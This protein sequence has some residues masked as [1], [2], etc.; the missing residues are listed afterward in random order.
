MPLSTDDR[1]T[2][3]DAALPIA[4]EAGALLMEGWRSASSRARAKS[5]SD[6]VTDYD[7][8]SEA[9]IRE[10]L[11]ARFPDCAFIGEEGGGQSA[12]RVWYVD[13][14]DGT[15][16]FAHGHP[17]FCV[18]MALVHA[19]E[20]ELGIVIAPALAIEWT[21]VRGGG[22]SRNGALC[23][24]SDTESLDDALLSTG[25]PS[26]RA[27]RED[28]NYRAFLALDAAS[29][30]VRRCGASAIELA[31]VADG[32]YDAFWDVG[33]K[34]WDVAAS[35]LFVR[36]AGGLV[37]DHDG[38]P[39]IA[40]DDFAGAGGRVLASNGRLHGQLARGLAGAVP[41]PPVAGM[42]SGGSDLGASDLRRHEEV[43]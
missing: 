27:S 28:N 31:M 39:L 25:F 36:E 33:L 41:L 12:E 15:T 20:P 13:P 10:R 24:V 26:W 37:S 5:R 8:R 35:T 14:I 7:L 30:G 34:P 16:N 32:S 2:L 23:R 1:R 11:A 6:L 9:L 38:A 4:R 18:S 3:L 17:F 43:R 40:L 19:G 42:R 21:A 29:H 22:A